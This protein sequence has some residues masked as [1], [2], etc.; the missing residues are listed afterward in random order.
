MSGSLGLN[1]QSGKS[2]SLS[3]QDAYSNSM[4]Q[5]QQEQ[6][7][8]GPQQSALGGLYGQAGN[9]YND[10]LKSLNQYTPGIMSQTQGIT[11]SAVNANQNQMAG[12]AYSGL[13]ANQLYDSLYKSMQ[14]PSNTS[15]IYAQ[16]MGGQGNNYADAMKQQYTNDANRAQ[17]MMLSNLDARA[18]A[19]GMSGG[20]RHG[21]AQG[22][23]L[24]GINDQLQSQLAQTGY[25]TF[26]KDL[27][28]KLSIAAMADT[29]TVERQQMLA[30]MLSNKQNTM[31]SGI[32]NSQS[33]QDLSQGTTNVLQLPWAGLQSYADTIGGPTVLN[34]GSSY[35]AST[36]ESHAMGQGSASQNGFGFNTA[37]SFGRKGGSK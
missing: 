26:D 25:N 15:S 7:V 31:S 30:D 12:G 34:K 23:G 19:S 1:K 8:F 18:A 3:L 4:N 32:Q 6:N 24:E 21:I 36:D 33:L 5:A 16:M 9:T 14:Q 11:D 27:A 10:Y 13:D 28:N 17:Q 37:A 22:L 2:N 29:N 35:G 20:S